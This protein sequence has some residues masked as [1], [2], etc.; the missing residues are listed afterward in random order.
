MNIIEVIRRRILKFL[1]LEKLDENPNGERFTFIC[2]ED[3]IKRQKLQ[4]Y[5]MW[6]I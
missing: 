5:K 1:K 6:Y 4:E 3:N 2:D